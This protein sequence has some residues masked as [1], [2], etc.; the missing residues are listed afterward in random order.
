MSN[1]SPQDLR[2]KLDYL[3]SAAGKGKA[4]A[5][6]FMRLFTSHMQ[7]GFEY[8]I[9]ENYRRKTSKPT[10]S[11]THFKKNPGGGQIYVTSDTANH[12]NQEHKVQRQR[13]TRWLLG[14]KENRE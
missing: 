5:D 13:A 7:A 8:V 2:Q 10:S 4:D 1:K 11:Y 9:G 6:D 12:I 3:V 14:S